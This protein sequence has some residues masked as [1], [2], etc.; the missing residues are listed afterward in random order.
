RRERLRGPADV[1][2][3]DAP[4][5]E[6]GV[7]AFASFQEHRDLGLLRRVGHVLEHRTDVRRLDDGDR[8]LEAVATIVDGAGRDQP[9][10]EDG[11]REQRADVET[12]EDEVADRDV[13][14]HTVVPRRAL[15]DVLAAG[16]DVIERLGPGSES[17]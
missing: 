5:L 8:R 2:A 3:G 13:R 9:L 17:E 4:V 12:I 10:V 16:W 6:R 1:Y 11:A 14:Q 15:D 7:N